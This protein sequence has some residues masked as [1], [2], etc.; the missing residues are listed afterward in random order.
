MAS[1]LL[2]ISLNGRTFFVTGAHAPFWE[3]FAANTWEPDT[4]RVFDHYIGPETVFLDVGCWIGPTLLYGAGRAKLAVGFEPDP[5]AFSILAQNVAANPGLAN[6]RIHRVAVAARKGVLR[7]GSQSE[8]GDSMSSV[9]FS[10]GKQNWEAQACRLEDMAGDWPDTGDCF[11]KVDIEGGEYG[12][13]PALAGFIHARRA[14]V[15]VSFHQRFFLQPYTGRG[16]TL[17]ILGELRLLLRAVGLYALLRRFPH[18]Y[19][20]NGREIQPA[21]FLL[22]KNWRRIETLLLSYR[23][24]PPRGAP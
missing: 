6:I 24:G 23:P 13:L 5:A 7:I 17:K 21:A 4:I 15:F 8:Q 2:K 18:I 14:T 16:L 10:G 20:E 11:V 3:R 9:L 1:D 12:T 19:D 22:R